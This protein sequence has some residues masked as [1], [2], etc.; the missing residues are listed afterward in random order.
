LKTDV[1][2]KISYNFHQNNTGGKIENYNRFRKCPHCGIIWFKVTA[3][4]DTFCGERLNSLDTFTDGYTLC[5]YIFRWIEN[6]L[7]WTID[8]QSKK[9]KEKKQKLYI[10]KKRRSYRL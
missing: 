1:K 6:E 5:G 9:I 3:C 2:S 10:R 8:D 7:T 4:P